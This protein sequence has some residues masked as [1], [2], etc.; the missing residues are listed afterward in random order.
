MRLISLQVGAGK[1][2][3]ADAPFPVIPLAD[4]FDLTSFE[5]ITAVTMNMDLIVACDTGVIH[6]A[7]A[8]GARVWNALPYVPDWR[9]LLGCDHSP[10][11]PTMRLFRSTVVADW[12]DVF[13]RIAA[14]VR[15]LI[16]KGYVHG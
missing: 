9:W 3:V 4:Q 2:Q 5:D 12:G 15:R 16:T 11:Y 10:W 7:G 8:L 13:E 14:E 1:E 6:L